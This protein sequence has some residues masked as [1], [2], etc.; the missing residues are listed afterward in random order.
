MLL[1]N[2]SETFDCLSYEIIIAK[3]NA[4][5]F[6]LSALKLISNYLT[7]RKERTKINNLYNS[8]EDILF[9]VPQGSILGPIFLNI[10]LSDLFLVID[11][12]DLA[13]MPMITPF[14]DDVILSLEDFAKEVFQFN[15][16]KRNTDKCQLLLSKNNESQLEAGDFLIKNSIK[17]AP[18]RE[19]S[20]W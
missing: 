11:D 17:I 6:L 10:F 15:R 8:W 5:G 18:L 3:L 14:S 9:E 1:T 4:Y 13:D 7:D 12:I 16:T 2:L 20:G 19:T